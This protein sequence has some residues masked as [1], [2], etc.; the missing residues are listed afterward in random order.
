VKNGWGGGWGKNWT[1]G[2]PIGSNLLSV[3]HLVMKKEKK[4]KA[5]RND[6]MI[7]RHDQLKVTKAIQLLN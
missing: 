4:K 7:Y 3:H 5:K 1:I 2:M 6:F